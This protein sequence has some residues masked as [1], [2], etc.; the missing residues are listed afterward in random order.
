MC[1]MTVLRAVKAVWRAHN[2]DSFEARSTLGRVL[3]EEWTSE[4]QCQLW[5]GRRSLSE[6]EGL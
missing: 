4:E 5:A 1:S 3:W 6:H 2:V